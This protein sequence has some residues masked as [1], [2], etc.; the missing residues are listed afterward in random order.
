MTRPI[1]NAL[2]PRPHLTLLRLMSTRVLQREPHADA[3]GIAVIFHFCGK[4]LKK[5]RATCGL[6]CPLCKTQQQQ[7]QLQTHI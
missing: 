3:D 6:L 7:Q 1:N 4:R 2:A 5:Y